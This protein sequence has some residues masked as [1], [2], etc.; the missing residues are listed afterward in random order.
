VW[1]SVI[2][3]SAGKM[4]GENKYN[5]KLEK[6]FWQE[7]LHYSDLYPSVY[8]SAESKLLGKGV[9][10]REKNLQAAV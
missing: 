6:Y 2:L 10:S 3:Q 9:R 7:R 1:V 8:I 5:N 4:F